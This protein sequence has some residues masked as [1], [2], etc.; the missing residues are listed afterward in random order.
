MSDAPRALPTVRTLERALVAAGL[1][2]R[3]ARKFAAAGWRAIASEEQ[4][5]VAELL[6]LV[7]A[8]SEKLRST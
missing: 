4:A 3:Q 2:N 5:E 6:D 1:S 7:E 8:M